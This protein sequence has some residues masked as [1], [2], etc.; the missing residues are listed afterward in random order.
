M[1]S[2]RML[3]KIIIQ[4]FVSHFVVIRIHVT[5]IYIEDPENVV[6]CDFE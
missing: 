6:F 4:A 2:E 5:Q 3:K 1:N